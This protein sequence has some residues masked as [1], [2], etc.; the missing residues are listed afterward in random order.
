[1]AKV[2]LA[3]NLIKPEGMRVKNPKK[4]LGHI[5]VKWPSRLVTGD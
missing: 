5:H 2:L 3:P 4:F 1:L